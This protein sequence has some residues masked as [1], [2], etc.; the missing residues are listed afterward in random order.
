MAG[1]GGVVVLSRH[2]PWRR[3]AVGALLG[4][5]LGTMVVLAYVLVGEAVYDSLA[6]GALLAGVATFSAGLS[7]PLLGRMLD[8]RGV[9][10]GLVVSLVAT[11]TLLAVQTGLVWIAA[12][13]WMLFV[14]AA[15]HGVTYA[16]VPG[17][18]RA[19]L[20]PSVPPRDLPR[21]NTLDAVLTEVG[22][23]AGPAV[24]GIVAAVAGHIPVMLTMTA[25]VGVAALATAF[26]RVETGGHRPRVRPWR[27]RA[28]RIVY[29]VGLALGVTVGV[30]ESALAARVVDVGRAAVVAGPLL[31]AVAVASGLAGL[32]VSMLDDQRGN[33]A[34]RAAVALTALGGA[35]LLVGAA[36][37]LSTLTLAVVLV[38][39]P[40]APLNAIGAQ[41]LQ[42]TLDARQLAEG[43]SVYTAL[44]LIGVGIGD[45]AT[46]ILLGS[47]GS[48]GLMVAAAAVPLLTLVPF[49]ATLV[50]GRPAHRPL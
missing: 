19:L 15:G 49:A 10:R 36:D 30:F 9:R 6:T 48:A 3:W 22:F 17:G 50:P 32:G 23:V 8:A 16:A 42:D 47:V 40:I 24:A 37:D 45:L 25:V 31:A 18:Y 43:F 12:P 4:R 39:V 26:L 20:V 13:V 28:A 41:L 11:A 35:L 1:L 27:H 44:I 38:G 2:A 14:V 7:A 46:G 21:A 34:L 33:R 29:A 5:M